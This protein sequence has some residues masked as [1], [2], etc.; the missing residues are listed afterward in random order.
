M[1]PITF[2]LEGADA[3]G[4]STLARELARIL[5][6]RGIPTRVHVHAPPPASAGPW[7]TA[8]HFALARAEIAEQIAADT[9]TRVHIIDRWTLS[10]RV[11]LFALRSLERTTGASMVEHD[12]AYECLMDAESEALPHATVIVLDAP[13]PVLDERA[14]RRGKPRTELERK[15]AGHYR[16]ST[17]CDE[18]IDAS[19][20][21]DETVAAVL[22]A[23]GL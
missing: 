5:N 14:E 2:A 22:R 23:V 10:A 3:A 7:R 13:D 4:K 1:T 20:T 17:A 19:G 16:M 9:Q 8:L 12:Y 6:A 18:E 11:R 15:E 21:L